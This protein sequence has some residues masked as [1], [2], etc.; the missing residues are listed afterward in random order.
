MKRFVYFASLILSIYFL[1]ATYAGAG[2]GRYVY[3]EGKTLSPYFF[4]N[5][6]KPD[7]DRL[8]LKSI[9]SCLIET[10]KK[11]KFLSSKK[12]GMI[13]LSYLF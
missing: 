3:D 7:V 6:D 2:G 12:G 4:I 13:T 10:V 1:S 9:E 11:W 5:S 8:P